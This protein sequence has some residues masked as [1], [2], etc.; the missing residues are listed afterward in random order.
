MLNQPRQGYHSH[1]GHI[2]SH[3][4]NDAERTNSSLIRHGMVQHQCTVLH[5]AG[6]VLATNDDVYIT[7]VRTVVRN[8]FIE[9]LI[10]RDS[11]RKCERVR[12]YVRSQRSQAW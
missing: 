7:S 12:A 9:N 1:Y 6:G 10:S 3:R 2:H 8:T 5:R 11:L 4:A